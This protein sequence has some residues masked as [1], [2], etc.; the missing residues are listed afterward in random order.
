MEI[1]TQEVSHSTVMGEESTDSSITKLV[2]SFRVDAV[3]ENSIRLVVSIDGFDYIKE[4]ID[5]FFKP[6]DF[7]YL[8][9]ESFNTTLDRAGNLIALSGYDEVKKN[10]LSK[11]D[12]NAR[13]IEMMSKGVPEF[14]NHLAK[15][16]EST[17][18]LIESMVNTLSNI[19]DTTFDSFAGEERIK[20]ILQWIFVA[21]ISESASEGKKWTGSKASIL[22]FSEA[23]PTTM[24]L[25]LSEIAKEI[26][27]VSVAASSH[28]PAK[29]EIYSDLFTQAALGIGMSISDVVGE[30]SGEIRL[31]LKSGW[32]LDGNFKFTSKGMMNLDLSKGLASL[33]KADIQPAPFVDEFDISFKR[34]D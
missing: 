3:D 21:N 32:P 5:K 7:N 25:S 22:A 17:S 14:Q 2:L 33:S 15:I 6:S 1:D 8:K 9:G 11:I 29:Q 24:E 19:A 12:M 27:H 16:D 13:A 23:Q 28:Q 31:D 18:K 20:A 26:G 34:H 30:T 4:G 10:F